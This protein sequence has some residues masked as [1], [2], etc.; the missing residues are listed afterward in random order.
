MLKIIAN[1]A[2]II[3]VDTFGRNVKRGGELNEIGL[4]SGHSIII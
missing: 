1:P 3:T 2:Q 4:L